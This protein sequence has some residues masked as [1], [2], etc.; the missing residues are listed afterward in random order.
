[1]FT[2]KACIPFLAGVQ[3]QCLDSRLAGKGLHQ[4]LYSGKQAQTVFEMGETERAALEGEGRVRVDSFADKQ[5]LD[6]GYNV[7]D[8]PLVHVRHAAVAHR[9]REHQS[10]AVGA[11]KGQGPLSLGLWNSWLVRAG[12][13]A[14]HNGRCGKLRSRRVL[15]RYLKLWDDQKALDRC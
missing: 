7:L 1:M 5:L 11:T 15:V 12:R 3:K 4:R 14:S 8:H 13:T 10:G 6:L 9:G 2:A